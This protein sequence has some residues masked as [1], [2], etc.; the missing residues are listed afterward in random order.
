MHHEWIPSLG[1]N[2]DFNIDGLSHT[3]LLIISFIG[4][5]VFIYAS[6]YMKKYKYQDR[7]FIYLFIF[8]ASML[9]LVSSDN[10]ILMFVF[11][12]LTSVSSYLLIGFKHDKEDVRYSALQALIVTGAG[13]LILLAGLILLSE[14]A[15]SFSFS[16]IIARGDIIASHPYYNA[17]AILVILGAFTK[18]AQFPFH[19]WLP[20]AMAAPSP[21]SAL[22]HSATMVKAGIYLLA[23]L[24]PAMTGTDLWQITL[25]MGGALTML[26]SALLAFKQR[27]LKKLLAYTT[28]NVLGTLTMLIGIGTEKSIKAMSIYLVAHSF[29]KGALFLAAGT[30]DYKTGSRDAAALGG[31]RKQMPFTAIAAALAGL[32]MMGLA[33]F[34]GFIAKE[35]LYDVSLNHIRFSEVLIF[36]AF[37]SGIFTVV[38]AILTGIKP[39]FMKT[40]KNYEF[41]KRVSWAMWIGPLMLA[42]GG[43]IFGL[44]P[45]LTFGPLVLQKASDV[46]GLPVDFKIKLWHGFNFVFVLSLITLAVG[47]FLFVFWRKYISKL[48]KFSLPKYMNPIAYYDGFVDGLLSAAKLQTRVIQNGYLHSYL[49]YILLFTVAML[50]YAFFRNGDVFITLDYPLP[51][52]YEIIIASIVWASAVAVIFMK[53]RLSAVAVMGAAGAGIAIM[54]LLYGAP[55]LAMTQF[56]IETLTVI[57]FILIVYRLPRFTSYSSKL[58]KSIDFALALAFGSI[59]SMVVLAVSNLDM[60]TY[61]KDYF[62]SNS[63]SVAKGNNIVNVILVDFR[64]F[65]TF[66]EIIV[67]SIAAIGVYSMM[68]LRLKESR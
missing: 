35:T 23:R 54:F 8:F 19:F 59:M 64:A 68:K 42:I 29:Y 38:V 32:S 17:I 18:S 52:F 25:T 44:A 22:L 49:T 1:I 40:S 20:N 15:G 7:F 4:T 65:D 21:V 39:F 43:L 51:S 11:W 5:L 14:A 67:L 3:F 53:G 63:Y 9:G 58:R 24:N 36:A 12:E 56:A 28:V 2:F 33:P 50:Y 46:L 37:V 55:D 30:V 61:F 16:E 26:I 31:L 66:G 10:I 60:P 48:E 13:G 45:S 62:A 47:F 57:L 41:Q 34:I 27:D 6:E